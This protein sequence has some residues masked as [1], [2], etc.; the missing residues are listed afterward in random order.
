MATDPAFAEFVLEQ[1]QGA[2]TVSV[3]KMFGEY[4]LYCDGKVVALICD[5]QLFLK[6]L[7]E[8]LALIARPVWG[9]PYPRAKPHLLLAG[10]LDDPDLLARLIRL[11]ADALPAPAPKRPRQR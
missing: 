5:D 11:V 3:R 4:A 1:A 9:P 7:P 2:G 8:A 6:P 10:E